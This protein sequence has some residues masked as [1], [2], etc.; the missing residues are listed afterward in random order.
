[1]ASVALIGPGAIGCAVGAALMEAGHDVTFCARRP[2]SQLSIRKAGDSPTHVP[3]RVVTEPAAIASVEWV[4][5]CVKTYQVAAAA[6]WLDAAVGAGTRVAVLQ[7]GVEHRE[8]CAPLLP[9]A[10]PIVPVVI[11]LPAS[12]TAPGDVTWHTHAK[13]TV[14]DDPTGADFCALF[15]NS[16]VTAATSDD[17]ATVAWRKLCLNAPDGAILAL[18]GRPRRVWHEPGIADLGRAILR[19]CVAVARAEGAALDDSLI[20]PQIAA[21]LASA[22]DEGNSMYADRM[23]SREMEWDARNAVVA[24]MGA[25][26]GIPTPV[27]GA[28]VPLLAALSRSRP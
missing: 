19:E 24:R 28:L 26:H 11:N 23:A 17:F 7:N 10:T 1:M 6:A 9:A 12:R 5:L 20:E 18:T 25:K 15:A 2:F 16:F 4:L 22:P 13:L 27:S 8:R 14:P 21:F 3:A